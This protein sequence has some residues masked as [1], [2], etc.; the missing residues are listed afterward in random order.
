MSSNGI[1]ADFLSV[2]AIY[3]IFA[4]VFVWKQ[5]LSWHFLD[6]QSPVNVPKYTN[7]DIAS[8]TE[9]PNKKYKMR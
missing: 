7:V 6:F 9:V 8:N 5:A 1:T 2:T 4:R 3:T